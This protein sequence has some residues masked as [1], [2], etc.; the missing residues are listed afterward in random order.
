MI[1]VHEIVDELVERKKKEIEKQKSASILPA[2]QSLPV[3]QDDNIKD[4]IDMNMD[5]NPNS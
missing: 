2:L 4:D 5:N 3:I 1:F